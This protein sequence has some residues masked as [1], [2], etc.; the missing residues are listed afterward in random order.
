M[1][2]PEIAPPHRLLRLG[3]PAAVALLSFAVFTPA[4]GGDFVNLDDRAN[5]TE[6]PDFRGLGPAQLAWMFS[7]FDGHYQPITWLSF[8][9]DYVLWGLDPRGYHLVNLLVHAA[10][11]VLVYLL[12]LD[13][14]PRARALAGARGD[15]LRWAA[16]AGALLFAVHP[17]RVESVAWVTERKDV[18]YLF[19]G[20][21]SLLFYLRARPAAG[22][23][24]RGGMAASVACFT[25]AMGSKAMVMT[26][27]VLLLLLDFHPLGRL[28]RLRDLPPLLREKTLFFAVMIAGMAA[29]LY[30][31]SKSLVID[32]DGNYTLGDSLSQPGYRVCFYLW[33]I[34][35]PTGLQPMYTLPAERDPTSPLM[36]A[37]GAFA[38]VV[39]LGLLWRAK[40]VP[41]LAVGWLAFGV[42]LS[43]TLGV[44]QAGYHFAADRNAYAAGVVPAALLAGGLAWLWQRGRLVAVSG[45]LA[46]VAIG[47]LSVLSYVQSQVWTNSLTLWRHTISLEPDHYIA[48]YNLGHELA[49]LGRTEEAIE[50][51][52][53]AIHA[54][55]HDPKFWYN[56][57]LAWAATGQNQRALLD[58]DV[59]VQLDPGHWLALSNRAGLKLSGGDPRGAEQDLSRAIALEPERPR[60]YEQRA[61]AR[62]RLGD[63]AGARADRERFAELARRP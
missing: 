63:E 24:L 50:H 53:Q 5:I 41:A 3:L 21:A 42:L 8:G 33:K 57:G 47:V 30:A 37:C 39:T 28:Q 51:Y 58:F 26:W 17:L 25:L 16:A 32:I 34:L 45:A 43:P 6:N 38:V 61:K 10:T 49:R 20:V 36:L 9:L 59:V 12:L 56:R 60:L 44:I 46:V 35:F 13:L 27:P 11:S 23:R 54:R 7:H 2:R 19:F 48:H 15:V 55:G 29:E 1:G 18:L 4:L 62:A 31:E 22:P 40:R 52:T 14:L